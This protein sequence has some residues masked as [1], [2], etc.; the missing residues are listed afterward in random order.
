MNIS[1]WWTAVRPNTLII[2]I[3]PVLIGIALSIRDNNFSS[4]LV[5]MLTL[6]AAVFI[7]IGT[8]LINDLYDY[9]KGADTKDRIG[10]IRVTQSGIL[11]MDSIKKGAFFVLCL[12]YL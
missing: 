9:L 6:L 7:Q 12:H 8:N 5:A 10:P 2:S 3:A 1:T 11:S 4:Y